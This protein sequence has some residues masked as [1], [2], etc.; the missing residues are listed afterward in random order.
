[1]DPETPKGILDSIIVQ[2]TLQLYECCKKFLFKNST[3][4]LK[5]LKSSIEVSKGLFGK[6]VAYKVEEGQAAVL[7]DYL[8]EVF[9]NIIE[10]LNEKEALP[11][12]GC[13][14]SSPTINFDGILRALDVKSPLQ[15]QDEKLKNIVCRVIEK[16]YHHFDVYMKMIND[17]KDQLRNVEKEREEIFREIVERGF[18]QVQSGY[19]HFFTL[20]K[21]PLS[22]CFQMLNEGQE[23]GIKEMVMKDLMV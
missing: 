9:N 10:H 12:A 16:D 2:D 15:H 19:E 13:H 21:D 1:V 7:K 8:A 17:S 22:T 5:L 4:T 14:N 3:Q 23:E 6:E 11:F 20:N 18:V